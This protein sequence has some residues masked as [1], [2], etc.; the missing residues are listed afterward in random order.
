MKETKIDNFNAYLDKYYSKEEKEEI[1]N[2][3][4]NEKIVS[5][6]A[7]VETK[8]RLDYELDSLF[9][10]IQVNGVNVKRDDL[11]T[12]IEELDLSIRSYNCCIRSNIYTIA[13]LVEKTE[14]EMM[15]VRNLGRKSFK[16][17]KLKLNQRGL[18]FKNSVCLDFDEED[19]E[20]EE[21]YDYSNH[22]KTTKQRTLNSSNNSFISIYDSSIKI[23][24]LSVRSYHGLERNGIEKIKDLLKCSEL[25]LREFQNLGEKSINEI[26]SKLKNYGLSLNSSSEKLSYKESF[27]KE[28]E[29]IL[30]LVDTEDQIDSLEEVEVIKEDLDQELTK[31]EIMQ[32]ENNES[33]ETILDSKDAF[34]KC[35]SLNNL[36]LDNNIIQE[37][38]TLGITTLEELASCT[39]DYIY[40]STNLTAKQID[41]LVELLSS[42]NFTFKD[43]KISYTPIKIGEYNYYVS[44]N[45]DLKEDNTVSD[46]PL[47][48]E[49]T[50][51][52]DALEEIKIED[53]NITEN[54]LE[55]IEEP[56]IEEETKDEDDEFLSFYKNLRK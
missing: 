9:E 29:N 12:K 47:E 18:S 27:L 16:E 50:K 53:N 54:D 43:S 5:C 28:K 6:D 35:T 26:I 39:Y 1:I 22:P 49:S 38:F 32:T 44:I 33:T 48:N 46:R 40:D 11:L 51:K 34:S 36:N 37:L 45:T 41:E 14:E 2:I 15:K 31:V 30:P 10:A 42:N 8:Y 56:I 13:D 23:L 52:V 17:I 3:L 20:E 19:E 55:I 21:S 7:N 25:E 24:N 4:N